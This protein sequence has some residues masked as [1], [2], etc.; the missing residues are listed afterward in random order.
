MYNVVTVSV[1]NTLM[2]E[3]IHRPFLHLS[4]VMT[5]ERYATTLSVQIQQ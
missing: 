4:K 5:N 2:V 3:P 1:I